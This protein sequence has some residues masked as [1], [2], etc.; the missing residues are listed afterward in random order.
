MKTY[1]GTGGA[2]A[3]AGL[4]GPESGALSVEGAAVDA[5]PLDPM[6]VQPPVGIGQTLVAGGHNGAINPYINPI[7]SAWPLERRRAHQVASSGH[8]DHGR[9]WGAAGGSPRQLECGRRVR[10]AVGLGAVVRDHVDR[11]GRWN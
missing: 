6:E 4:A 2:L 1:S 10:P 9:P 3:A 5:Y 7:A 8:V 11:H